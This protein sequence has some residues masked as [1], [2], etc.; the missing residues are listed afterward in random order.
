[1]LAFCGDFVGYFKYSKSRLPALVE[2]NKGEKIDMSEDMKERQETLARMRDKLWAD[3][4][5]AL[6]AATLL[7]LQANE[8]DRCL[9]RGHYYPDHRIT[10][11]AITA[12]GA[13]HSVWHT[14]NHYPTGGGSRREADRLINEWL[15]RYIKEG[16]IHG[17]S[18]EA[19]YV[20][21]WLDFSVSAFIESPYAITSAT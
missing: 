11:V 9:V 10:T 4:A 5:P 19:R 6:L 15:L 7:N 12:G 17:I 1:M 16:L 21:G 18:I 20:R 14:L 3:T 8:I 13:L 2:T